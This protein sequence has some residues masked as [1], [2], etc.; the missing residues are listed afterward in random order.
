MTTQGQQQKIIRR[1]KG[2]VVSDK[3]DKTRVVAVSRMKKHPKY[4]KYVRVTKKFKAHDAEN[5]YREGDVVWIEASRPL[6]KE[7]RWRIVGKVTE[8]K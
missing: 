7:K 4:M 6:S 5:S 3:M 8:G 2:I 1:L